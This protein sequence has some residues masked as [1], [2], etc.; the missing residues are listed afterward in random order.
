MQDHVT[1]K[2]GEP[3]NLSDKMNVQKHNLRNDMI[4]QELHFQHVIPICFVELIVFIRLFFKY[5][6]IAGDFL[7]VLFVFAICIL[8]LQN[9]VISIVS[10]HECF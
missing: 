1:F 9:L 2:K 7:F 8:I 3:F 6:S 10:A 4:R 5:E